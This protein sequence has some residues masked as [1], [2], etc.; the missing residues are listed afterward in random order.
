VRVTFCGG[1]E[2][3][4]RRPVVRTDISSRNFIEADDR[5]SRWATPGTNEQAAVQALS[6]RTFLRP[7]HR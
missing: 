6:P 1:L 5:S 2:F 4:I 7:D 3:V